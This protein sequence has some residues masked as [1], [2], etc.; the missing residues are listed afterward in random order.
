MTSEPDAALTVDEFAE[1]LKVAKS[2]LYKLAQQ[3][4]IPAQK[5]GRHWRFRK[6]AIDPWLDRCG[7]ADAVT[8]DG[9]DG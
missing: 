3:G 9:E 2:A 8:G 1:H 5:V 7:G 4:R 6:A